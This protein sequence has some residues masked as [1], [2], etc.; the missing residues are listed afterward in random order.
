MLT[1][2]QRATTVDDIVQLVE[3][4]GGYCQRQ[5]NRAQAAFATGNML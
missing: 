5:T 3:L 4:G 2:F 1:A